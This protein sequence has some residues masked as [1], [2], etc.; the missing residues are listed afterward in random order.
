MYLELEHFCLAQNTTSQR[1][2]FEERRKMQMSYR[3]AW[4]HGAN[5]KEHTPKMLQY[6]FRF[7]YA[8]L[9]KAIDERFKRHYQWNCFAWASCDIAIGLSALEG[10]KLSLSLVMRVVKISEGLLCKYQV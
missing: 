7:R 2:V 9:E 3:V 4:G 5:E 6:S 1:F 10:G 8:G